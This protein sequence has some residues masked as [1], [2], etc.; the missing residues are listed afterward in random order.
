MDSIL[1]S[2]IKVTSVVLRSS[3]S[4]PCQ[5]QLNQFLPHPTRSSISMFWRLQDFERRT[6]MTR[7]GSSSFVVFVSRL[8]IQLNRIITQFQSPEQMN[9]ISDVEIH[10][11]KCVRVE[12]QVTSAYPLILR[13]SSISHP[14]VSRKEKPS[15]F[16]KTGSDWTQREHFLSLI[17]NSVW[18]NQSKNRK[19]LRNPWNLDFANVPKIFSVVTFWHNNS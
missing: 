17:G 10:S 11:S 2:Q 5:I 18:L 13:W 4:D 9:D 14:L 3:I 16:H 15:A 7:T 1:V 8:V 19:L 12:H 6:S